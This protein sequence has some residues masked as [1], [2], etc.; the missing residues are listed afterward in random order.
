MTHG[1]A[2]TTSGVDTATDEPH[3]SRAGGV[4]WTPRQSLALVTRWTQSFPQRILFPTIWFCPWL[5]RGVATATVGGGTRP[6]LAGD[7]P[8]KDIE[9]VELFKAALA[10]AVADG[11]VRRSERGVLE[12][13]ALRVGVGRA[14]FD[15]MLEAARQDE[16]FADNIL[17]QSKKDARKA[18][19]L[20][21]AQ[22]RID[23]E[24]SESERN[25]LVRI[26]SRL[27]LTGDE[28]QS[29]YQAGIAR[30]DEIRSSRKG[31]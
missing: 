9:Q 15:A 5:E 25:L 28:F 23:G 8:V 11:E 12:G 13:L 6:Q 31:S 22:A 18:L 30:A 20:L 10:I 7:H 29:I 16:A 14:S 27:E 19:E 1:C 26:A 17:I 24:I 3:G 21:V 4:R 2:G